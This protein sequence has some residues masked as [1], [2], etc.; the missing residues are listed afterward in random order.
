MRSFPFAVAYPLPL[1]LLAEYR[2]EL[3][4]QVCCYRCLPYFPVTERSFKLGL[5]ILQLICGECVQSVRWLWRVGSHLGNS[6]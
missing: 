2:T 3:F 4:S 5:V 1:L 6:S